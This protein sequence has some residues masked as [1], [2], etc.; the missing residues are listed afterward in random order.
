[1]PGNEW[2][3]GNSRSSYPALETSK[4]T[5]DSHRTMGHRRSVPSPGNPVETIGT[6]KVP[7]S[8]TYH[9]VTVTEDYRWLEDARSER[10]RSWTIAQNRRTRSYLENLPC[11]GAVRRRATEILM[12]AAVRYEALR[13][14]GPAYFALKHQPP[15]QQPFLVMLSDLDDVSDERVLVAPDEID[16]SGLATIDWYQPCPDGSLVA[17]SVSSDGTRDGT[18]HVYQ[19]T[20]GELTGAAV[21]RV[22]G[23]TASGSLAWAGDSSGFWCTRYPSPGERPDGDAGFYQEVWYHPLGGSLEDGRRELAG[24]F[25]DNRIA[26]NFLSASPDGRW[27]MDRAQ[28]GDGGQWQVFVRAQADGDWWLAADV[29]DKVAYAAFGPD[30]LYLLSQLD[31]PRG[32]VLRLPLQAGAT[33]AHAAEVVPEADITIEGGAVASPLAVTDRWLWLLGMDGAL[34]SLWL[35]GLYGKP[36]GPVRVPPGCTVDGLVRLDGNEVAYATESFTEPRSWWRATGPL[37]ARRTA[38]AAQAPLDF[39]ELEV[40]QEFAVSSD[41]TQVPVT[42]IIPRGTPRDG[43]APAVLT[44]YGGFGISLKPRLDPGWLPW[45]EQGG[46]LAIAHTRGGGE[47]GEDWH[48]AGRLAAKQNVFDDF[49]AC[50]RLLAEWHLAT[51]ERLAI[52]GGSNGGLLMGAMLTQHPGLSR[53]VVA[54]VPVMDM[55]RHE[56]DP[57]GTFTVTEYGTV[58]DPGLFQAM[59][60]YSPYHNVKNGTAYPAVLLTAGESDPLAKAYHAKKMAARLQAATSS[61][62]PV[63]LR[64]RSG[65]HGPSSLDQQVSELTD[66]YAFL[67]DSLSIGYRPAADRHR[68]KG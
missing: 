45:L 30:A 66:I 28:K 37:A 41:G 47:Y 60:G 43:T 12:A 10:T 38:L 31:A 27:V 63:L 56:L 58:N 1:M 16:G 35:F 14:A 18:V 21:P 32:K 39:P 46:V 52:L 15:R 64:I 44:G 19:A 11:Y 53:A 68:K 3:D 50:A 25:A 22:T 13:H 59:R 67:F 36:A 34:S 4:Q 23:G 57:N 8:S 7:V 20:S 29:G 6:P 51:S 65:G 33:V 2:P 61:G 62:Q 49:A 40:A 26:E 48:N 5:D 9:G 24:V 17:V 55:L 42:L 54:M